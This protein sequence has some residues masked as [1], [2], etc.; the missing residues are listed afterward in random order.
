MEDEFFQSSELGETYKGSKMCA[1]WGAMVGGPIGG[2]LGATFGA[3]FGT[4][5]YEYRNYKEED[6]RYAV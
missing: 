6:L 1:L 5:F 2:I 4:A 3:A